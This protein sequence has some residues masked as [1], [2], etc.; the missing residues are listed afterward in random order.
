[1]CRGRKYGQ[2]EEKEMKKILAIAIAAI[3]FV[4]TFVIYTQKT[5]A[6]TYSTPSLNVQPALTNA[7][8]G[9]TFSVNVTVSDLS[10]FDNIVGVQFRL[11]YDASLLQIVSVTEGP[12]MK[13]PLWAPH[14]TLYISSI[15]V[16]P[17]YGP[18][19]L[20]GDLI[21]PDSNG[22]WVNI[23]DVNFDRK[24]DM[25]D[26]GIA[27]SAFG[28][29]PGHPRWNSNCDIVQDNIIN[30]RDIGIV[31][32][33]F[34][35]LTT[36][37]SGDGTLATVTFKVVGEPAPGQPPVTMP[38]TL[39]NTM[40]MNFNLDEVPHNL[41]NGS[42]KIYAGPSLNVQPA[43]TDTA[44]GTTF[45][46]NI[47]ISNLSE[48]S[49]A[50]GVQFR[51]C[52]D[53]SLLKA[54]SVTEG[55]FMKNP[56]WASHGTWYSSSIEVDATYGPCVLVGVL[57]LPDSSGAWN[58]FPSG[59]GT[60][61]TVTFK[62]VGEPAPGQPPVTMPLTLANSMVMNEALG[63]ISHGLNNGSVKIYPGPSMSVQPPIIQMHTNGTTF[64]VNVT[65]GD[66]SEYSRAVG[67]QFRL[68]YD[69]SLLQIVSVTEGP[70][71]KNPLWASHG[72]W[73][74][75]SIEVDATYGPCVLVGVLILPDSSGAWNAFP[76]GDG[77]LATITFQ[78]IKQESGLL[79]CALA[80]KDTMVMNEALGDIT[81]SLHNGQYEIYPT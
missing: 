46:V 81:H 41:N 17:T 34:G 71:M 14:G 53:A 37:P 57:I 6:Q 61:A 80:L 69:A 21:L 11:C 31:A 70:F 78:A 56:L 2:E 59:D 79:T 4:S 74:S 58:A 39:A 15:E 45:S 51:L 49:R 36:L 28:A 7:V 75:S 40:F 18:C 73:Y 16:D 27:A 10:A 22:A 67:V 76:S 25:K 8:L 1:M 30:M 55:P 60:L 26:I 9:N 20:I 54:V 32:R 42:V 33:N 5:F 77:T 63:D 3:L 43:L 48:L 66:L 72:T 52:Y 12:F 38:L 62:G 19:V 47:T 50:V 24:V 64:S 68:C 23:A 44:L 29:V 13:T 65:L 35:R